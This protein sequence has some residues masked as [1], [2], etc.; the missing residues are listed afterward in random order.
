[1]QYKED[2]LVVQKIAKSPLVDES[3]ADIHQDAIADHTPWDIRG[4]WRIGSPVIEKLTTEHGSHRWIDC[5]DTES[6]NYK[7][8]LSG[9]DGVKEMMGSFDFHAYFGWLKLNCASV[10]ADSPTATF[11]W[12]GRSGMDR[13]S[14]DGHAFHGDNSIEDNFDDCRG[15]ITFVENGTRCWGFIKGGE[16]HKSHFSGWLY[17]NGG[18]EEEGAEQA[19]TGE[20]E[21][22]AE[23]EEAGEKAKEEARATPKQPS[24][25]EYIVGLTQD[26]LDSMRGSYNEC[27]TPTPEETEQEEGWTK[28]AWTVE[29]TVGFYDI[30][31]SVPDN[32]DGVGN[33]SDDLQIECSC[34]DAERQAQ[35]NSRARQAECPQYCKHVYKCLSGLVESDGGL[36]EEDGD[37]SKRVPKKLPK[38]VRV[39]TYDGHRATVAAPPLYY[40]GDTAVYSAGDEDSLMELHYQ[41]LNIERSVHE[42]HSRRRWERW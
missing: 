19:A 39:E 15:E 20:V 22:E 32:W 3:A 8:A 37:E 35:K 16:M 25:G 5:K 38:L 36:D 13:Y 2:A 27:G 30:H 14:Y 6:V 9:G 11:S 1:M 24:S 23:E 4:A 42:R 41:Y 33:G 10:T 7:L 28:Y 31:V 12:R 34:P 21:T 29:G 18:Q 17:G 40:T 26:K